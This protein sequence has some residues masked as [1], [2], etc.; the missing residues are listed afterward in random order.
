[1]GWI[2]GTARVAREG[3]TRIFPVCPFLPMVEW[4]GVDRLVRVECIPS[5][6]VCPFLSMEQWDGMDS[7]DS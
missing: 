2:V 6:S 4:D 5:V 3:R 1:M 7:R